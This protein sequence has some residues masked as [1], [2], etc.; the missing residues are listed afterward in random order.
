STYIVS[1][2]DGGNLTVKATDSIEL[3]GRGIFESGLYTATSLG[4]SGNAGELTVETGNLTVQNSATVFANSAGLGNGGDVLIEASDGVAVSN[5]GIVS[6]AGNG[7]SGDIRLNSGNLSL[8]NEAFIS[9]L[10]NG[11]DNAGKIFIQAK[12][13]VSLVGGSLIFSS[14]RQQAMGNAGD[15]NIETDTLSLAEGSEIDAR[16]SGQG[17]AGNINVNAREN[18]FLDGSGEFILSDGS[19]GTIFTRIINSVDTEAVGNAGDIQLNTGNLSVTNGASLFATA[20]GRGNAG[21]ININAREDVRFDRGSFATSAVNS[22]AIGNGGDI[23]ITTGSLLLD[24]RASLSTLTSGKG[25]AGNIKIDAA[26]SISLSNSSL[27]VSNV[28]SGGEG[29]GGEIDINSKNLTLTGGSQ[30]TA[31][32]FRES[33][34][35]PGGKGRGGEININASESVTLSGIGAVSFTSGIFTLTER[36][37]S[38]NAGNITVTTDDFR[39][40]DDA[41]VTARTS[42]DGNAGNININ[43][44]RFEA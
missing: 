16:T 8:S 39:L 36:G 17:N 43:A 7:S 3:L 23:E 4:S 40:T 21:N 2:G 34:N 29:K 19:N 25:D 32:V 38:G 41:I 18:I 22:N 12:D 1:S 33:D 9:N 28:D 26:D 15:I 27:M 44:N 37:A 11:N 13:T 6:N 31:G 5:A 42:N 35:I 24:N 20:N 14:A 10:I 30:I